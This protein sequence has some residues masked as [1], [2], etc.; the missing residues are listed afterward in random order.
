MYNLLDVAI[1]PFSIALF[2]LRLYAI[3]LLI[4]GLI[5]LVCVIVVLVTARNKK[6]TNIDSDEKQ[7][8]KEQK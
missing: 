4:I 1:S 3:P 2:A 6:Q 7:E 8:D 5:L